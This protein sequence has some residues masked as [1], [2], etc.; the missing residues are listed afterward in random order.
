MCG[1]PTR[2]SRYHH[3]YYLVDSLMREG[4][5]QRVGIVHSPER[6]PAVTHDRVILSDLLVPRAADESARPV[7]AQ[8]DADGDGTVTRSELQQFLARHRLE[9][10][11]PLL[12]EAAP[13]DLGF[14]DFKNFLLDTPHRSFPSSGATFTEPL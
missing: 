12:D 1:T 3:C 11:A 4:S 14:A 13:R 5:L 8:V 10:L 2:G 7:H 9:H 6:L